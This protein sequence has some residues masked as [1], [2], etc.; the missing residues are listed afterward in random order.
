MVATGLLQ[1]VEFVLLRPQRAGGHFVQQRLPHVGE[2]RIHQHDL[3]L[4]VA[5][6]VVAQAGGQLQP[7]GATADDDDAVAA[8]G[9]VL[10]GEVGC[11]AAAARCVFRRGA[12][13]AGFAGIAGVQPRQAGQLG[14][15]GV[16]GAGQAGWR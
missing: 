12:G 14:G 7:A 2:H 3:G 16:Q 1:E 5:A 13:A 15:R 10:R 6:G 4:A 9:G 11:A 8:F